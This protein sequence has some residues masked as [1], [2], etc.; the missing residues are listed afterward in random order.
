[1]NLEIYALCD[2]S[3]ANA[4]FFSNIK[5]NVTRIATGLFDTKYVLR[6]PVPL[7]FDAFC[8]RKKKHTGI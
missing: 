7:P 1:M 4:Q 3:G 2:T 8:P 5:S 6:F